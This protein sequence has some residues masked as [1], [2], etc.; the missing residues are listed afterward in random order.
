MLADVDTGYEGKF[1]FPARS[2][3]PPLPYLLASVPRTGS[4]YVSHLLWRSGCLGAPLEYLNYERS[5][6]YGFASGS[7]ELQQQLWRSV[8]ARRTSPNGVFGLKAFPMQ[9]EA[10]AEGNR[11]LLAEVLSTM[12]P[13]GAPKRVVHLV[14]RDRI[15][16]IV[17]YARA[18][19]SGVWRKEQESEAAP[20][21][22]YSPEAMET[23][24]RW[25]S[26]QE[27]AWDGM[28][29]DMRIE[30]LRL[31]YEDAVAR[32]EETVR[33]VADYLGVKLDPAAEVPVPRIERQS[34]EGAKAW[35]ERVG[36]GR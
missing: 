3:P 31:C 5:G 9:L 32:P 24:G 21:P 13:P 10:L 18:T 33:Q 15:A 29:A 25:L 19:L 35:V 22:D 20:E 34:R 11:P 14:R 1:D 26:A 23:A 12:L 2:G 4:T 36:G 16:H 6:P 28:F 17:S 27:A 7:P 30:P 8:L